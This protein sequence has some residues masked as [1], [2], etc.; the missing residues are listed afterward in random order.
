[1]NTCKSFSR[2]HV[3]KWGDSTSRLGVLIIK[4]ILRKKEKKKIL[5][6]Q[7]GSS[8]IINA[9]DHLNKVWIS[10]WFD[11]KGVLKLVVEYDEHISP[12]ASAFQDLWIRAMSLMPKE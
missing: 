3:G 9:S 7:Y 2:G 4:Y 5:K 6:D 10:Q 8:Q 12:I 11:C 1:M